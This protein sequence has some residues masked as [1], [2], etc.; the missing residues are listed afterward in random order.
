[1]GRG[2]NVGGF[3]DSRRARSSGGSSRSLKAWGV[4]LEERGMEVVDWV[5]IVVDG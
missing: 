3:S 4:W 2:T 1:M 5:A